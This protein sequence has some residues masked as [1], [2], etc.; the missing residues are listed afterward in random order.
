[1]LEGYA[2]RFGRNLMAARYDCMFPQLFFELSLVLIAL[3][4]PDT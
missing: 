4:F 2:R 1:M 3:N